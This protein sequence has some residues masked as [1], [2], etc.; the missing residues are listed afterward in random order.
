MDYVLNGITKMLLPSKFTWICSLPITDIIQQFVIFLS[1]LVAEFKCRIFNIYFF[2]SS[3]KREQFY[4][5]ISSNRDCH[6]FHKT[7]K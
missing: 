6:L 5:S 4:C 3:V 1:L 2:H 7:P